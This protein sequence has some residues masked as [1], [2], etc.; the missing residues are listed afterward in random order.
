MAEATA[1]IGAI[2][3]TTELEDQRPDGASS[4]A[5]I[6]EAARHHLDKRGLWS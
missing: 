3:H 4:A 1:E 5:R 2:H 6:E